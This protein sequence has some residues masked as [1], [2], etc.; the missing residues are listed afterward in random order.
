[1][2]EDTERL[3]SALN[4]DTTSGL[5]LVCWIQ[6]YLSYSKFQICE[7]K[8][9]INHDKTDHYVKQRFERG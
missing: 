8:L 1:M 2:E 4:R 5:S 6:W 3:R 9:Y 7:T